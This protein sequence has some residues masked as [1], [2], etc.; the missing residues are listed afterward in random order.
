MGT[1]VRLRLG[2]CSPVR[3]AHPGLMA[4]MTEVMLLRHVF[5]PACRVTQTGQAEAVLLESVPVPHSPGT[6]AATVRSN[7]RLSDGRPL[8]NAMIVEA[9][10]QVD[11][12]R[13]IGFELEGGKIIFRTSLA[14]QQLME[15]LSNRACAI[16]VPGKGAGLVGTGPY[17]EVSRSEDDLVLAANP[18]AL[19]QPIVPEVVAKVYPR[20]RDGRADA[21][22]EALRSG[23]VDISPDLGLFEI[24]GLEGVRRLVRIGDSTGI[25]FMHVHGQLSSPEAR[26][27]LAA[28]IDREAITATCYSNPIA[29][30]ATG[31]L[32]PRMM[33]SRDQLHTDKAGARRYF[34]ANPLGGPLRMLTVWGS[35]PYL[36]RLDAA[37]AE[38]E[39]QLNEVGVRIVVEKATD[40]AHYFELS[41]SG[42][43]DLALAGWVGES[44][45]ASDFCDCLLHGDM[46]RTAATS[47]SVSGNMA[48]IDDP[49]LNRAL[50]DFRKE[51][52]TAALRAV[53]RRIGELRPLVPLMY[54][55][56]V[57][58]HTR[59]VRAVDW[60]RSDELDLASAEIA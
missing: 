24:E 7:A 49:V 32:P 54:G 3:A 17:L 25:L 57:V 2:I 9:L 14:K 16:A 18:H 55:A 52:S 36:P 41:A 8:T 46:V 5:E 37:I 35:R 48:R 40:P 53:E 31:L 1:D 30:T 10:S 42:K 20:N 22:I 45:S 44:A 15:K 23:E 26:N 56:A 19:R 43:F 34:D 13:E 59:R 50:E 51:H 58:V 38:L 47:A 4:E 33:R 29:Y 39:R 28:A 11:L 6:Y 27:A 21:L 12:V 60:D